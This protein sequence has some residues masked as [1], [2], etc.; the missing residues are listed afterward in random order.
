VRPCPRPQPI[1][2]VIETRTERHRTE[3]IAVPP[4]GD[5][6]K[7]TLDG[8]PPI[9]QPSEASLMKPRPTSGRYAPAAKA[10]HAA[11]PEPW[12]SESTPAG[13]WTK[14]TTPLEDRSR[15]RRNASN[16]ARS[17]TRPTGTT[18]RDLGRQAVAALGAAGTDHRAAG[19][20]R[21][22][23]TKP[24]A[25]GPASVIRLKGA[26]HLDPPGPVATGSGAGRRVAPV[27]APEGARRIVSLRRAE[28]GARTCLGAA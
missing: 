2:R 24:V 19:A 16:V 14:R 21:H 11:G 10:T 7:R 1:E 3:E 12:R 23:V 26:L 13:T 8:G 28:K 17:W 15:L 9:D 25:L 4:T 27:L 20:V 18:A 22:T 5:R 6:A